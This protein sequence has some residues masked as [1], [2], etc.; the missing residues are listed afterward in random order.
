MSP[1]DS[2]AGAARPGAGPMAAP[3]V[4]LLVVSFFLLNQTLSAQTL[5]D[6]TPA[7]A[8]PI[9]T[10]PETD[11]VERL[12]L[13]APGQP[14]R[15]DLALT[16]D[17]QAISQFWQA[18]LDELFADADRDHQGRLTVDQA[19][20]LVEA[21]AGEFGSQPPRADLRKA[22]AALAPAP[23]SGEPAAG[24][25]SPPGELATDATPPASAPATAAR[26]DR[27]AIFQYLRRSAAPFVVD[28]TIAPGS[29]AAPALFGL[30]DADQDGQLSRE[31]LAGAAIRL[32]VR[33]FD[34]DGLVSERELVI[35]PSQHKQRLTEEETVAQTSQPKAATLLSMGGGTKPEEIAAAVLHRYDRDGDNLVLVVVPPGSPASAIEMSLPAE[36]VQR[37]D[38]NGDGQLDAAELLGLVAEPTEI[39]LPL[40]F[41]SSG[42]AGP[43]AVLPGKSS[44]L[45]V[46]KKIDGGFKIYVE[47][48]QIDVN[49]NNRDPR[50]NSGLELRFTRFDVDKSGYLDVKES[51]AD[52]LVASAFEGMDA[53]NDGKVMPSEFQ[54]YID[55]E[56]ASA[57]A[58]VRL[59]VID[60][61][62]DLFAVIDANG[63]GLLTPRELAE[64]VALVDTE[65]RNGDGLLSGMEIPA[66]WSLDVA[67]GSSRRTDVR[68][69]R[70][71]VRAKQLAA[72]EAGPV[73]FRKMDRNHDGDISP[74]E[75]LGTAADFS[76]AD[77][78]GDGLID[79]AEATALGAGK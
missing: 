17:G 49:R 31:E 60:R 18:R 34:D 45:R 30:I 69:V 14:L 70:S 54:A 40:A 10:A 11:P 46:R 35:D 48:A 4:L 55:V 25:A 65:D 32:I 59:E 75:F 36:L 67:R 42:G 13:L 16:I 79:A 24:T 37:L 5:A 3:G 22:L 73:W 58:R 56:N 61:G 76:S 44:E 41:G 51:R 12:I 9:A 66:R 63:D 20:R 29:A 23:P 8:R 71:R 6:A 62:Q 50:Q 78:S 21:A 7:G 43:L 53:D 39:V 26:L 64:A 15:I 2:R 33:D 52:P 47:D 28:A 19:V 1:Q 38:A 27:E 68:Q 57:A 72:G 77:T 74:R